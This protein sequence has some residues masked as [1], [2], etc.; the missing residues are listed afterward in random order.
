MR[1]WAAIVGLV[2]AWWLGCSLH[3]RQSV[4]VVPTWSISTRGRAVEFT[5]GV[6]DVVVLKAVDSNGRLREPIEL[7]RPGERFRSRL[8][9]RAGDELLR[10]SCDGRRAVLLRDGD[11][12]VVAT[13]SD[14]VQCTL[15][16][17]AGASEAWFA[18]GDRV[19]V[20]QRLLAVVGFDA[21]T[22]QELWQRQGARM[23]TPEGGA[24]RYESQSSIPLATKLESGGRADRS[25]I[26]PLDVLTGRV[27]PP[28]VAESNGGLQAAA[29]LAVT[30]AA[31]G[32]VERALERVAARFGWSFGSRI[33]R[34]AIT[35]V[36]PERRELGLITTGTDEYLDNHPSSW[37]SG[38]DSMLVRTRQ[39]LNYYSI[40]PFRDWET[41]LKWCLAPVVV[42]GFAA[43]VIR[44]IRL[45]T[46]SDFDSRG[47]S[48]RFGL[49]PPGDKPVGGG[50]GTFRAREITNRWANNPESSPPS[51]PAGASS[52]RPSGPSLYHWRRIGRSTSAGG[53]WNS[54]ATRPPRWC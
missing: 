26:Q 33:P 53:R 37:V 42:V 12:V 31:A 38:P 16:S 30:P 24:G 32:P 47:R 23:E 25:S 17:A 45:T 48:V 14:Q 49:N 2:A 40:P 22:G 50:M 39:R 20:V 29:G 27:A 11:V 9:L 15:A 6:T 3:W 5:G 8:A 10:V 18:G 4:A 35:V 54:S 44:Q 36:A 34:Y 1:K 21:H 43:A 51:S 7:V 28:Q 19:V 52:A 46:L 13:E 41:L